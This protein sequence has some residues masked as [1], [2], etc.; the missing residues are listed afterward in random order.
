[1]GINDAPSG[2]GI[3]M[4]EASFPVSS[5]IAGTAQAAVSGLESA[6]RDIPGILGPMLVA[7]G[8]NGINT[9]EDLAACATDDLVG[10]TERH[11]SEIRRHPGILGDM[12][13]SR[14]QCDA[15]IL[16]ARVRVGWIDATAL[17]A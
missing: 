4:R 3:E 8:R 10:W 5:S 13:V 14:Q 1:M 6:F 16:Q 9:I 11:G 2:M 7:F 17:R 12:M 15:I